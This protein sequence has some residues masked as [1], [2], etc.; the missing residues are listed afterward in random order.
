MMEKG[1]LRKMAGKHRSGLI[2]KNKHHSHKQTKIMRRTQPRAFRKRY[3]FY[4]PND[5]EGN[6]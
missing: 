2:M 1:P 4:R 6:R 3:T 5:N